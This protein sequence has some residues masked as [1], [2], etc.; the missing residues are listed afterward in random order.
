VLQHFFEHAPLQEAAASRAFVKA[1]LDR[2]AR[3]AA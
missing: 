1:A 2:A 3:E